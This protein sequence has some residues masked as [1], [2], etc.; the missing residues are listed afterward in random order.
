ASCYDGGRLWGVAVSCPQENLYQHI[1]PTGHG[2]DGRKTWRDHGSN[3]D[4]IWPGSPFD[5]WYSYSGPESFISWKHFSFQPAS[6][7]SLKSATRH[8]SSLFSSPPNSADPCPL[9]PAFWPPHCSTTLSPQP[10]APGLP[11]CLALTYCAGS[12]ACPFLP[13]QSGS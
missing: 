7:P 5:L 3:C 8:N 2:A 11:A 13:W 6:S 4:R 12:S 9:W 10:S 1:W